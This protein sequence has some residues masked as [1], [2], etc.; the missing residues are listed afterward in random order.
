MQKKSQINTTIIYLILVIV[1][2]SFLSAVAFNFYKN[3]NQNT[4]MI[5][6]K[7]NPNQ[8]DSGF[9]PDYT[10]SILT[11]SKNE[12]YN[13]LKLNISNEIEEEIF[14]EISFLFSRNN[15]LL[16]NKENKDFQLKN[17]KEIITDLKEKLEYKAYPTNV[18]PIFFN[19]EKVFLSDDLK[20]FYTNF[21]LI[22]ESSELSSKNVKKTLNYILEIS[23]DYN[24]NYNNKYLIEELMG[25]KNEEFNQISSYLLRKYLNYEYDID[26]IN[27]IYFDDETSFGCFKTKENKKY[28]FRTPYSNYIQN[29]DF[30]IYKNLKINNKDISAIYLIDLKNDFSENQNNNIKMIP[31]IYSENFNDIIEFLENEKLSSTKFFLG[32]RELFNMLK[33]HI[34]KP[35]SFFSKYVTQSESYQPSDKSETFDPG[36]TNKDINL[37][38]F[39][40]DSNYKNT[41]FFEFDNA[42]AKDFFKEIVLD[43]NLKNEIEKKEKDMIDFALEKKDEI[44]KINFYNSLCN[45]LNTGIINKTSIKEEIISEGFT[46]EFISNFIKN[47][48]EIKIIYQLGEDFQI[49]PS[50]IISNMTNKSNKIGMIYNS[51]FQNYFNNLFEIKKYTEIRE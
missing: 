19:N 1:A 30:F 13:I 6:N 49:T 22:E 24:T 42:M 39:H 16:F 41:Y 2:V 12:D 7:T 43:S 45:K 29:K 8:N 38:K 50:S 17:I 40:L 4:D 35:N 37:F 32:S 28:C 31:I 51:Y 23:K 33:E 18:F 25:T 10:G 20:T 9:N 14:N 15:K 21:T 27:Y 48:E 3:S 34:Q 36:I 44:C 46:I 5:E 26:E 11:V 47:S